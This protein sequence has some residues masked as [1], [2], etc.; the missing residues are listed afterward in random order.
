MKII[1]RC[2]YSTVLL[3]IFATNAFA[4][5]VKLQW[6]WTVSAQTTAPKNNAFIAT[7]RDDQQSINTLLDVQLNYQAFS[8]QFAIKGDDLYHS[9]SNKSA[10]SEFIVSELFWQDSIQ[11]AN[12]SLDLQLGKVRVDWGVGYGYRPLDIFTPYRR[13]PVGIQVEE[14]AGVATISYFDALGEWTLIYSNSSLNQQQGSEIEEKSE[15]QGVG[16]RRYGLIADTEYQA[17]V[18]YDDLRQ[19]L[20]GGSLVTVLDNAWEF[21]GSATYQQKYFSYQK[22]Q[23][24]QRH[25]SLTEQDNA[26]QALTG[27]TW[28]DITGNTVILEYWYDSRAWDATQWEKAISDGSPAYQQGYLHSN[29]VAHNMMLHWS[30]DSTAWANWQWSQG[31]WLKD[32]TPSIDLLYSPQ[33][34]GLIATQW[35]NYL[36]FDSGHAK[37]ELQLAAR[38]FTGDSTSAYANLPDKHTI[39]LNLKGRF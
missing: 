17:I 39:L 7:D 19:G 5:D 29:I 8:A 33:D 2:I 6:D 35:L 25:V 31:S 14:G 18:Y 16:V 30:L 22:T 9:D 10:E 26:Y 23:Q 27:L 38:F 1:K 4:S 13:N 20:V 36:L 34:N 11:F 15:Q 32:F 12:Y 24:N 3:T 28:T 21:H 37:T